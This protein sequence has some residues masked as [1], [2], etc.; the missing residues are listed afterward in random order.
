MAEVAAA[1]W[2]RRQRESDKRDREAGVASGRQIAAEKEAEAADLKRRQREFDKRQ[3]EM[4]VLMG[5]QTGFDYQFPAGPPLATGGPRVENEEGG[6]TPFLR[7][8]RD[9]IRKKFR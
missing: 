3:R 2:A 5:R 7:S 9:R 4:G 1:D 6:L 8:M